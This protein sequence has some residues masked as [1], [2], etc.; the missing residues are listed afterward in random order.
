MSKL[1]VNSRKIDALRRQ[2]G[3][4]ELIK[5]YQNEYITSVKKLLT[6]GG[7]FNRGVAAAME[8]IVAFLSK[9]PEPQD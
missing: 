6:N 4:Q 1:Q 7:D 8:I 9:E 5:Y 2:D 3:W